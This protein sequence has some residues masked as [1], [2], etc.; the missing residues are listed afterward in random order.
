[1]GKRQQLR[2]QYGLQEDCNDCLAT[3]CCGPC[4][5]CQEARELKNRSQGGGKNTDEY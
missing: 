3:A 2:N 5:V 4:A 1:M